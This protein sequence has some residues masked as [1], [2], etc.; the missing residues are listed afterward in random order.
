MKGR[1]RYRVEISSK[2]RERLLKRKS[3]KQGKYLLKAFSK[4]RIDDTLPGN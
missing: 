1:R 4:S 3:R 2:I